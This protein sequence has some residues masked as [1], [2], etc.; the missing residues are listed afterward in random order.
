MLLLRLRRA[1]L[2]PPLLFLL[3]FEQSRLKLFSGAEQGHLLEPEEGVLVVLALADAAVEV[4]LLNRHAARL[5]GI[6]NLAVEEGHAVPGKPARGG[7]QLP[8]IGGHT[9]CKECE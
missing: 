8:S 9:R 4:G 1:R 7:L 2:E 5:R 3:S 6:V